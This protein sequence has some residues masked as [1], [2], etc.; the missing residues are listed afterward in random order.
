M[1]SLAC[2]DAKIRIWIIPEDGIDGTLTEP[3][4]YLKGSYY[5][6]TVITG[7]LNGPVLF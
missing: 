7:P 4:L 5:F 3:F 1:V 6:F 2:D